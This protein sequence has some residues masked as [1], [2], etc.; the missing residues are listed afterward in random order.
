MV[1]VYEPIIMSLPYEDY[2]PEDG[3]IPV[4]LNG[5]QYLLETLKD[6][7]NTELLTLVVRY[8]ASS[9]DGVYHDQLKLT[10]HP[11]I[12]QRLKKALDMIYPN[13]IPQYNSL[14][15]I[16]IPNVHYTSMDEP[17][18]SYEAV[19]KGYAQV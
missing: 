13:E 3:S 18:N 15:P 2:V 8:W 1:Q 14:D 5:D 11:D 19:E 7:E 16:I 4:N 9:T 12:A 10:I 6:L 17:F